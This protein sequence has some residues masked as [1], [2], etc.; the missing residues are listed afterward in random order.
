MADPAVRRRGPFIVLGVAFIIVC[1]AVL[2]LPDPFL[3]N[4]ERNGPLDNAQA[5]WAY[6]LLAFFAV[7]QLAYAGWS[8]FRIERLEEARARDARLA[9]MSK[10]D[11]V[12]SLAQT[13]AALVFFTI[14]Y[15]LA[16]IAVTGQ[17]GG[18]WLFPVLAVA[19]S[20]WYYREIGQI[21]AWDALQVGGDRDRPEPWHRE[22]PDYTPPIARGLIP[23]EPAP[24]RTH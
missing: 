20:G 7:A 11:L 12:S 3:R 16:S 23:V 21:A 14:V 24:P 15:G 4:L 17:R 13:A 19:Q 8:V 2:A 6:R 10:A 1:V 18:F 9:A 5:G 22:P